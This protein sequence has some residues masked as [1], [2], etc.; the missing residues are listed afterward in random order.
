M[1]RFNNSSS[2]KAYSCLIVT[3]KILEIIF[4]VTERTRD[5]SKLYV[6]VCRFELQIGDIDI[7]DKSQQD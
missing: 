6:I 4:L 2:L 7:M 1:R 3:E 5:S